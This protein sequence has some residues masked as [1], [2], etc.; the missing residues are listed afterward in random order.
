MLAIVSDD[1]STLVPAAF[2]HDDARVVDAMREV[3]AA[4]PY[5]VAT[6]LAGAV[7]TTCTPLVLDAADAADFTAQ[8]ASPSRPFAERYPIRALMIVPMIG[9]GAVVGTLGVIRMASDEPYSHEA[10]LAL[11][12]LADRA[13]LSITEARR[14]PHR[15]TAADFEAIFLHSVDGVLFTQPD[16]RILA[17]NPAACQILRRSE[18]DICLAG[19]EGLVV[20]DERARTAIAA[21]AETGH[22]RTELTMC[23]GD[24]SQF[25]ADVSS[26][27][28]TN[29]AG[30]VRACVTFRDV[31][32]QASLRAELKEKT[33][34]LDRL[35]REDELTKLRNRRGFAADAAQALAIADRDGVPVQIVFFDVDGL[36]RIN[37]AHGHEA[38]DEVLRRFVAA[39]EAATR[40]SDVTARVGG[41]E[42]V[43]LLY[44]TT[45]KDAETT[46]QRIADGCH[47]V[48]PAIPRVQFSYGMV[49]RRS[50]SPT[51]LDHFLH[52]ADQRMYERKARS[53][54]I[55]SPPP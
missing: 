16:G 31:S 48:V 50:G 25:V 23:R 6:G 9:Y 51:S 49:E 46:V 2:H 27:V 26:N 24:G 1:G 37:D 4:E 40:G 45:T 20:A 10:L 15:L 14:V 39:L 43:A 30:D 53:G 8:V 54:A 28:F 35:A 33:E 52:E 18:R 44:G 5:P 17:A 55:G 22:V 21:R 29:E 19:R 11:E 34:L 12:A 32:D 7:V 47:D 3:L 41:D 36:K 42:F 13:A 38:G